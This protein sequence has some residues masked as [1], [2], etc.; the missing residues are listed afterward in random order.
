[1]CLWLVCSP[2]AS[3]DRQLAINCSRASGTP[4]VPAQ[5]SEGRAH[6]SP[7]MSAT[8]K[9]SQSTCATSADSAPI[10]RRD[11]QRGGRLTATRMHDRLLCSQSQL[12]ESCSSSPS[13]SD[14]GWN[15]KTGTDQLPTLSG[16]GG[17]THAIPT[18]D[19]PPAPPSDVPP[20]DHPQS[21]SDTASAPS[22]HCAP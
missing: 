8:P 14:R 22:S 11:H 2:E 19:Y 13:S 12:P 17:A 21:G 6:L 1:M 3:A 9:S 20:A 4:D 16:G 18:A 15:G 5:Q 7:S 10:C